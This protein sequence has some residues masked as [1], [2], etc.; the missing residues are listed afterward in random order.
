MRW[1]LPSNASWGQKERISF[2]RPSQGFITSPF[3]L[4]GS[5]SCCLCFIF[6]S[7][8]GEISLELNLSSGNYAFIQG[9]Y[10]KRHQTRHLDLW[11]SPD[12]SSTED[13]PGLSPSPKEI[14]C[15]IQCSPIVLINRRTRFLVQRSSL[16]HRERPASN[17]S[18]KDSP[19]NEYDIFIIARL[20]TSTSYPY[21]SRQIHT[22]HVRFMHVTARSIHVNVMSTRSYPRQLLHKSTLSRNSQ[23]QHPRPRASEGY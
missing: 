16:F 10:F 11:S 14:N 2:E 15:P 20:S 22:R 12:L 19:L 1:S 17:H 9:V 5:V 8:F 18:T 21:S 13:P 23:R 4:T 3:P 7:I 6:S